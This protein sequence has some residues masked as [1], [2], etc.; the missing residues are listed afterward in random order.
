M[1]KKLQKIYPT[2][3]SLLIAQDLWRD[4]YQVL[5]IIFL[6]KFIELNVNK[7]MMIQN[8]KHAELNETLLR[9]S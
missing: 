3:Y 2:H 9:F 1:E 7:S 4:L 8:V 6:K 5:L